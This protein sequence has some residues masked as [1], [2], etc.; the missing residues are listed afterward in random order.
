MTA[1]LITPSP[2]LRDGLL[3]VA[4]DLRTRAEKTATRLTEAQA[5]V[6]RLRA[7]LEAAEQHARE[8]TAE[9]DSL[10]ASAAWAEQQ[11]AQLTALIEPDPAE[12]HA[13]TGLMREE[14]V[15]YS[16]HVGRRVE[17]ITSADERITGRL[18]RADAADVRIALPEGEQTIPHEHI[19]AVRPAVGE[20]WSD[21]AAPGGYVCAA[22]VPPGGPGLDMPDGSRVC[23][24]PVESEP[25]REH[26]RPDDLSSAEVSR[27][28]CPKCGG[29]LKWVGE[30]LDEIGHVDNGGR[31]ECPEWL[32][33]PAPPGDPAMT[34]PDTGIAPPSL[35][36]AEPT[37]KPRHEK[38]KGG[39]V[40]GAFRKVGLIAGLDD[41]PAD[42]QDGDVN[43]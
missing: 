5:E 38:P 13:A 42:E 11:A 7:E 15:P 23:G 34:I 14:P 1:P 2:Y 36:R 26:G 37:G 30:H 20:V 27:W 39:R 18:I 17:I 31:E 35:P 41:Q 21:A 4:T 33:A 25:C 29:H 32:A 6:A 24:M 3:T 43:A 12:Q 22:P 10:T 9:H 16:A 28:P 19:A 40:T 8:V